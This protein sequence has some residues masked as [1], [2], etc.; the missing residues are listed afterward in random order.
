ME[1]PNSLVIRMA[2]HDLTAKQL[3]QQAAGLVLVNAVTIQ[4]MVC[5]NVPQIKAFTDI[6]AVFLADLT[7]FVKDYIPLIKISSFH[8]NRI[9]GGQQ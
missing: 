1:K 3:F 2:G 5:A 8:M 4:K 9:C 7:V 6:F